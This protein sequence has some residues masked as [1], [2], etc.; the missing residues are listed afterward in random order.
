VKSFEVSGFYEAT[1]NSNGPPMQQRQSSTGQILPSKAEALLS[2]V[3]PIQSSSCSEFLCL[4]NA[5]VEY[6]S[7]AFE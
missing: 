5:H 6:I 1:I 2:H 3:I 4:G 7:L